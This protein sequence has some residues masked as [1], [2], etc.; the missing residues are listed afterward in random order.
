MIRNLT[1]SLFFLIAALSYGQIL[2]PQIIPQPQK[3]EMGKGFFVL[4]TKTAVIC[5][6]KD[7]QQEINYLLKSME[8]KTGYVL[9]SVYKLKES[10]RIY[11]KIND[12]LKDSEYQID[13]AVKNIICE[14]GSPEG[15]FYAIQTLLQSIDSKD[16]KFFIPS[17]KIND[18]PRFA[19]RGLMLDDSRHFF[20]KE[21]VKQILDVMAYLKM[22]RFHMHLTDEP[23]WRI[24]IKKYPKLTEVGSTGTWDD[25][26]APKAFYT[27]EDIK[28][29]VA[30]AAER[31]IMVIP[32]IDMPG[33]ATAAS[34]AYPE[35]SGGG[36]GRW[37]GF[38]FHPAKETT[39][40]F[41]DDV[42]TEIAELFPAPYIHIGGDEVHYGNQVWF[43]DPVIQDFIKE[44]DLKDEVGM[45]HYFIRRVADI[46]SSK[47]KKMIGWDEMIASGITP[48]KAVV[49]WW[50]HDKPAQL[51]LALDK[52]FDVIMTPRIPC[53]FDFVQDNTQKI[54]RR[55]GD[56]KYNTLETVYNFPGSI[57][58][59]IKDNQKQIM[60]MQAS[61]WTERI[62]DTQRL[63]YMIFPRL[64]AISEDAWTNNEG[65]NYPGFVDKI[66]KFYQFLDMKGIN[67]F[68]IFDIESTPEPWGPNKADVIAEG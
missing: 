19:W 21:V 20:G 39:Y 4:D 68:N 61:T 56:G 29:I 37:E 2:Q 14:A 40:Q 46:V 51:T 50:R 57:E 48:D 6:D 55:W 5:K 45:E 7:I 26:N 18:S 3:T 17:M 42:L 34:R 33:H 13:V 58:N 49:M 8:A 41:L 44:N 1:L 38:T 36:T 30:Y 25:R 52:G 10:G 16:G 53:Y 63:Y 43:T 60:G 9:A 62:A 11:L 47:G 66:R 22:N 27:Q 32:E 65:K 12:K 15:I 67:Y 64:A 54:G 23:A 35:I 24:E 31:H 28:E 59:L